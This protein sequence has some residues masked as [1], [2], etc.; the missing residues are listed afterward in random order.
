MNECLNRIGSLE[1]SVGKLDARVGGLEKS[2]SS[3]DARFGKLKVVI[4]ERFQRFE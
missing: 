2:V 4:E 3:L 1:K